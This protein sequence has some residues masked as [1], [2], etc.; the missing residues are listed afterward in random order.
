MSSLLT[1][2]LS[3]FLAELGDKTQLASIMFASDK[4]NNP[5]MVFFAASSA[6]VASTFI[7]VLLG[8]AA[9]KWLAVFP[10]KLIAGIGFVA[11]GFWTIYGH[12]SGN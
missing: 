11:I 5:Y 3:V 9:E 2:F 6:L 10:L 1:I 7:A 12:F 8:S 4:N